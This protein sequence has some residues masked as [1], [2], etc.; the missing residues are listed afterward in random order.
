MCNVDMGSAKLKTPKPYQRKMAAYCQGAVTTT[1]Q[2]VVKLKPNLHQTKCTPVKS[3]FSGKTGSA[4][5]P[6]IP[7]SEW[8]TIFN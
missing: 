7:R 3:C 6:S 1:D 8:R 2:L 4:S 5:C